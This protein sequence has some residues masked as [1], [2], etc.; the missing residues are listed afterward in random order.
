MEHLL[1]DRPWGMP[2][3]KR[4]AALDVI[5]GC[6]QPCFDGTAELM[7]KGTEVFPPSGDEGAELGEQGLRM[8]L[9]SLLAKSPFVGNSE[10]ELEVSCLLFCGD[11]SACEEWAD[12]GEH[13]NLLSCE[14]PSWVVERHRTDH[15]PSEGRTWGNGEQV[16]APLCQT[17]GNLHSEE[18]G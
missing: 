5:K 14:T 8:K 7:K 11:G 17:W 4:D 16:S 12:E 13:Q 10:E 3:G 1:G 2:T 6:C 9:P 18:Q 15:T